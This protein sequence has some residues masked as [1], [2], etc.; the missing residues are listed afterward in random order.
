M[1]TVDPDN[2]WITLRN[3]ITLPITNYRNYLAQTVD[4]RFAQHRVRRNKLKGKD[5][6][7]ES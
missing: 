5:T 7:T 2:P 1:Q 3:P 4:P 6:I